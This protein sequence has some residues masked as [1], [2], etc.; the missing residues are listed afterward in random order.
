[1]EAPAEA[2]MAA[3]RDGEWN[4]LRRDKRFCD[5]GL[6]DTY[7]GGGVCVLFLETHMALVE[8]RGAKRG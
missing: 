2:D 5:D 1:M 3:K 8:G 7:R 4:N 6:R